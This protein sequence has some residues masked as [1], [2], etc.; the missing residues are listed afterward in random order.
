MRNAPY[1]HTRLDS[2]LELCQTLQIRSSLFAKVLVNGFPVYSLQQK[3]ELVY[4]NT[5][6]VQKLTISSLASSFTLVVSF[7]SLM[8]PKSISF[9][10]IILRY[11]YIHI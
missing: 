11:I 1:V 9:K 5:T 6:W 7:K 4:S 8:S 10:V 3:K 2:I